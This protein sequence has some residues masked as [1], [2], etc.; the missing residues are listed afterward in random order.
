MIRKLFRKKEKDILESYDFVNV[1]T[2]QAIV[3]V[4]GFDTEEGGFKLSNVTCWSHNV[5][6]SFAIATGSKCDTDYDMKI[7]RYM[8]LDGE[9]VVNLPMT[10]T[11]GSAVNETWTI[12]VYLKKFSAA[13][14]ETII[15]GP[16]QFGMLRST[17]GTSTTMANFI[18]SGTRTVFGPGDSL[19]LTI[20]GSTSVDGTDAGGTVAYGHDPKNRTFVTGDNTPSI[21]QANVPFKREI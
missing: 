8:I 7:E 15:G 18:L 6:S 13:G 2:G 5:S 21:F 17:A 14:V 16:K 9:V 4:Y 1:A 10:M 12:D 11:T 20:S 19:R 3:T